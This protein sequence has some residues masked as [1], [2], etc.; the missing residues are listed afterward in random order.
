MRKLAIVISLCFSTSAWAHTTLYHQPPLLNKWVG[1]GNGLEPPL[2]IIKEGHPTLRKIA[3]PV[4][5][6]ELASEDMQVFLDDLMATMKSA[7]GVGI[8][9]PQ[10]NVS[11]RIFVAMDSFIL[12]PEVTY[13]DDKGMKNSTEGCLS[14]PGKS[15]IVPRYKELHIDY[16]DRN[17]VEVNQDVRG[18]KAIVIQHEYDHLEGILIS[19]FTE[20]VFN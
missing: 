17:G 3:E 18:F 14:I 11:K 13:F 12:N 20:S 8:A 19:D 6:E 9:A 1:Q 16:F 7:G 4:S 5:I 10:V 2:E 15:Y